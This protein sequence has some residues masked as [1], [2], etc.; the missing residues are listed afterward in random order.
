MNNDLALVIIAGVFFASPLRAAE[1]NLEEASAKSNSY[2]ID[3][4]ILSERKRAPVIT[5][6]KAL[7][8]LFNCK[9][10]Y[11][12]P[13]SVRADQAMISRYRKKMER[14]KGHDVL[15]WCTHGVRSATLERELEQVGVSVDTIKGGTF[16]LADAIAMK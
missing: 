3:M 16:Y 13:L 8:K 11:V 4:R 7:T 9:K 14:F 6:T 15:M 5:S 2:C 10:T 1:L 12:L